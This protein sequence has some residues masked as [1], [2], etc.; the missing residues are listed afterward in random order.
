M[1]A[2]NKLLLTLDT[3][4]GG[5]DRLAVRETREKELEKKIHGSVDHHVENHMLY[6]AANAQCFQSEYVHNQNTFLGCACQLTL[7]LQACQEIKLALHRSRTVSAEV[8][9]ECMK[10]WISLPIAC[11]HV[12]QLHQS[13]MY[14]CQLLY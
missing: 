14:H 2:S 9:F 11:H 4:D 1:K 12:V 6:T 13:M 7:K 5:N 10:D 3:A 8:P